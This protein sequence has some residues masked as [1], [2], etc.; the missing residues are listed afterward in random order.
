[1]YAASSGHTSLSDVWKR[2]PTGGVVHARLEV[3]LAVEDTVSARG[4]A[5]H[6]QA[7]VDAQ[8]VAV[9]LPLRA[10][11]D[12]PDRGGSH[13]RGREGRS[14]GRLHDRRRGIDDRRH[15]GRGHSPRRG[16]ERRRR[17]PRRAIGGDARRH[18]EDQPEPDDGGPAEHEGD[19]RR[20]VHAGRRGAE[21]LVVQEVAQPLEAQP[22]VEDAAH[23]RHGDG[24]DHAVELLVADERGPDEVELGHGIAD[25][26]AD[27]FKGVKEFVGFR[28]VGTGRR[29]TRAATVRSLC[30]LAP[31]A[32]QASPTAKAR[33]YRD[34]REKSQTPWPR[35]ALVS[36]K[37]GGAGGPRTGAPRRECSRRGSR[38]RG[39]RRP[40]WP[41]RARC[42]RRGGPWPGPR[43]P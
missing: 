43:P 42:P 22:A 32:D 2:R 34:L 12:E 28:R 18:A 16:H 27:G 4:V 40:P 20:H 36:R 10:L 24:A 39:W 29:R 23:R 37:G 5:L 25:P 26:A 3:A 17:R 7:G 33:D 1:M 15:G 14:G 31:I 13:A 11:L 35:A 19:A 6:G 21:S 38:R 8:A 41:R 9:E 30:R